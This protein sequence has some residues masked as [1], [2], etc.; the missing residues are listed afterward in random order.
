MIDDGD[1]LD[2]DAVDDRL[3]MSDAALPGID[4]VLDHAA[5]LTVMEYSSRGDGDDREV[6]AAPLPGDLDVAIIELLLLLLMES[7]P[8]ATLS[9]FAFRLPLILVRSMCRHMSGL[10]LTKYS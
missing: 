5:P 4:A 6:P 1:G 3:D 9:A 8:L 7:C 10:A 2:V